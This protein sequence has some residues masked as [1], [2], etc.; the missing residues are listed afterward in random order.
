MFSSRKILKQPKPY[1]RVNFFS[2]NKITIEN[3]AGFADGHTGV[4]LGVYPQ[5]ELVLCTFTVDHFIFHDSETLPRTYI[6]P[7]YD[8]DGDGKS[9]ASAI[10]RARKTHEFLEKRDLA[11]HTHWLLS[12]SGFRTIFDFLIPFSLNDGWL[13]HLDCLHREGFGVDK[14]PYAV[15]KDGGTPI[16]LFCYR[17]NIL[18]C[19]GEKD[20]VDRHS[21]LIAPEMIFSLTEK[22]YLELTQG[23]PDP[24]EYVK[25]TDQILPGA[26]HEEADELPDEIA[27]FYDLLRKHQYERQL[28]GNIRSGS[29]FLKVKKPAIE[30]TL[31]YVESLGIGYHE[32]ERPFHFWKLSACPSCGEKGGNPWVLEAGILRCFR[33]T[34]EANSADGGLPPSKWIPGEFFS[35]VS[36]EPSEELSETKVDLAAAEKMI[37]DQFCLE[38]DLAIAVTPGVGKTHLAMQKAV[39]LARDEIVAYAMPEHELID[40]WDEKASAMGLGI[41]IVHFKGRNSATCGR[42]MDIQ[43]AIKKGY[44]PSQVECF[45]CPD[46]PDK[47]GSWLKCRYY[48]QFEKI[49]S[50]KRGLILCPT[51]QLRYLV[52]SDRIGEIGTVFIDE[53]ALNAMVRKEK[54]LKR[55]DFL[56]LKFYLSKDAHSQLLRILETGEDLYR[57]VLK[58]PKRTVGNIYT[59]CPA[60]TW[61]KDKRTLWDLCGLTKEDARS[62]LGKEVDKMLSERQW[63]LFRDGIN[64]RSL[65]WIQAAL[66]DG[67]CAWI[68]ASKSEETRYSTLEKHCLPREISFIVLDATASQEELKALFG[69]DF[70]LL[71]LNVGWEGIRIHIKHGMGKTKKAMLTEVQF[72]KHCKLIKKYIPPDSKTWLL[73]T[74]KADEKRSLKWIQE[75]IPDVEWLSSHYFAGRGENKFEHVDGVY[76]FGLSIHNPDEYNEYAAFLFPDNPGQQIRWVEAQNTAEIY[77]KAH[78]ARFVRYPGKTLIIEGHHWP[79]I[80]GEPD[81]VIDL[82]RSGDWFDEVKEKAFAAFDAVGFFDRIVAAL[83]GIGIKGDELKL[84]KIRKGFEKIPEEALRVSLPLYKHIKRVGTP[85]STVV[86]PKRDNYKDL[87]LWIQSKRGAGPFEAKLP[88]WGHTWCRAVGDM[89]TAAAFYEEISKAA[90]TSGIDLLLPG[91]GDFRS[92][93]EEEKPFLRCA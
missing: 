16:R 9:I 26:I 65:L 71:N 90:T 61:W 14:G 91:T 11:K 22:M 12:G 87:L 45:R 93:V 66:D 86:L 53:Q 5:T 30:Q 73:C 1:P 38:G 67:R 55:N 17:G 7:I 35:G 80:F 23:K 34:C 29:P 10:D 64:R 62:I 57:E 31:A 24:A 68:Q 27:D 4:Y 89:K 75:A 47:S 60:G 37:E 15:T 50:E 28:R 32:I 54:D 82:T 59:S 18:Q 48:E 42:Y 77:Q 56:F 25:W 70:N 39:S 3:S 40:E 81:K 44:Y 8:I 49:V 51:G 33:D 83:L 6:W 13:E 74:H 20:K 19:G 72:K 43:A 92:G 84:E 76:C 63:D 52:E 78:R 2:I 46:H 36:A 85:S 88:H 69:R 79:A 58:S 41:P 21:A